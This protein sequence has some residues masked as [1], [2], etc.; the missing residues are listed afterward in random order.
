M[1][2]YNAGHIIQKIDVDGVLEGYFEHVDPDMN[3]H[4]CDGVLDY[5]YAI[6][7]AL[8]KVFM[9]NVT[10][11]VIERHIARDLDR[12]LSPVTIAKY[13]DTEVE[14]LSSEPQLARKQR[15]SL[16]DRAERLKKGWD[17]LR[18]VMRTPAI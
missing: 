10:T 13:S 15:E 18:Q 12:I 17:F 3:K 1:P 7:K 16:T 2:C 8:Q 9:A 6:Y 11:Q 14:R 4:G 5:V